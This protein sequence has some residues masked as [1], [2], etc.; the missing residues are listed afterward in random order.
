MGFPGSSGGKEFACNAGDLVLIPGLRRSPG[1]G[2]GN[3]LQCSCL[4]NPHGQRSLVSYTPWGCKEL[5]TIQNCFPS[6]F[7]DNKMSE[8]KKKLHLKAKLTVNT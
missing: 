3:T 4:E 5:D 2:H 8:I 7:V 6:L 1:G